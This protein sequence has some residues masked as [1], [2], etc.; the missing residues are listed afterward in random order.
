MKYGDRILYK[1]RKENDEIW[2]STKKSKYPQ[3]PEIYTEE[4]LDIDVSNPL[5]SQVYNPDYRRTTIRN[6]KPELRLLRWTMAFN[7][8]QAKSESYAI[9]AQTQ[10]S[11]QRCVSMAHPILSTR[12]YF[13]YFILIHDTRAQ[14]HY[15]YSRF[16]LL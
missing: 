7:L 8:R 9:L 11:D 10:L 13:Y 14:Y 3:L 12:S 16:R 15:C 5:N 2:T 4:D 6:E 1:D